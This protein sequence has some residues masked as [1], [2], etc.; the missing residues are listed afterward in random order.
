[1]EPD[2]FLRSTLAYNPE[3][4]CGGR[5][6]GYGYMYGSNC[7]ELMFMVT[8]NEMVDIFY[9]LKFWKAAP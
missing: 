8:T 7:Q 9:E 1:L 3:N 5:L 4:A 2:G 6:G